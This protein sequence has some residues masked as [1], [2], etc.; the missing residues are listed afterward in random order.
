MFTRF[1]GILLWEDLGDLEERGNPE[2]FHEFVK[3]IA[4]S[5]MLR[6]YWQEYSFTQF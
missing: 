5:T 4:P 2:L 1:A 3:K 6:A